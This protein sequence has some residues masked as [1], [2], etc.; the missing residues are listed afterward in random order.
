M[1]QKILIADPREVIR[2][3]LRV[4]LERQ[5]QG[6]TIQEALTR[7]ELR[8][9]LYS[10]TYDM[11]IV[12]QSLVADIKMLPKNKFILLVDEPGINLFLEAHRHQ[13][14]GYLSTHISSELLS[15]AMHTTEESCLLDPVF[16]PWLMEHMLTY[17]QDAHNISVLSHR[18]REIA[19]LIKNGLDRRT[20]AQ[21]LHISDATLK[22]HIK[23]MTRK[24]GETREKSHV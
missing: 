14:R 19:Q 16:L 11:V 22:T 23:N 18:E 24:Q 17:M 4:I 3:G 20:I 2:T 8:K 13:A 5:Q 12:H 21:Q 10:Q 7:E 9:Q 6:N 15:I 1:E